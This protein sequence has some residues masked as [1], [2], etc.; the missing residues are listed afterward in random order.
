MV[1]A[2]YPGIPQQETGRARL[3]DI[4]HPRIEEALLLLSKESELTETDK[5][6]AFDH[7]KKLTLRAQRNLV[8]QSSG[9]CPVL[10]YYPGGQ[11][12]RLS[13]AAICEALAVRGFIVFALD[14]PRDAPVVVF[15]DGSLVTPPAPDNESYIWPR[16]A[17][18]RS[19]IDRLE[20]SN[21]TL[22]AGR[23]DLDR[24]GMFGHS[25]G[26]YL[27]NI[28]AVEDNRIQA[29]VNMDGFLWGIWTQHGT[30]LDEFPAEFVQRAKKMTKPVLRIRG[31]QGSSE[32]ARRDFEE[33]ARDFGGD[34]TSIA[35]HGWKHGDFA[36]APRLCGSPSNFV[37]NAQHPIIPS[38]RLQIITG[39]LVDFFETYLMD[40]RKQMT[41][42]T[43][44]KPGLDVFFR[45]K[46]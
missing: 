36:T 22:F 41:V 26:G 11:S 5:F 18:V 8:L 38:E 2:F 42:Q 28:C 10:I 21:A 1:T 46:L 7:L 20:E 31:D 33:E 27:S 40:R 6:A 30:G 44:K 9:P 45:Y 19:L 16:V 3:I 29:A 35:L 37:A 24:I 32:K 23:L 25:R 39:L 43:T 13:N 12:H 15:P 14:A 4:L 17:D 34:F